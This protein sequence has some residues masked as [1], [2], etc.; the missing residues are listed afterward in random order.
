MVRIAIILSLLSSFAF[1]GTGTKDNLRNCPIQLPEYD[2]V[3][4]SLSSFK[5]NLLNQQ[6]CSGLA[7]KITDLHTIM[8]SDGRQNFR[9]I[10]SGLE[11][12]ELSVDEVE[13]VKGYAKLVS[14]DSGGN[15]RYGKR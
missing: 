2:K 1:A 11:G 6:K 5:S 14:G 7:E 10:V 12:S 13:E 15:Y 4:S 9:N 8:G 3:I